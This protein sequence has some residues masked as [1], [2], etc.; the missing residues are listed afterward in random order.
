MPTPDFLQGW[1]S[2]NQINQQRTAG[3]VANLGGAVTLMQHLQAQ[4]D[5]A[6]QQSQQDTGGQ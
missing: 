6:A 4:Q 1:N 2:Q 5:Q 3:D